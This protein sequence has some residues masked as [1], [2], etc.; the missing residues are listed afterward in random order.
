MLKTQAASPTQ[1]IICIFILIMH[2][3][4][5]EKRTDQPCCSTSAGI[6][7]GAVRRP[8][9]RFTILFADEMPAPGDSQVR[10]I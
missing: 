8:P 2:F 5:R 3:S 10:D 7:R 9:C 1:R 4:S 6:E